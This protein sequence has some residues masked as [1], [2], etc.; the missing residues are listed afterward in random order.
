MSYNWTHVNKM[1]IQ[2]GDINRIAL[3][4]LPSLGWGLIIQGTMD[5]V[6][7]LENLDSGKDRDFPFRPCSKFQQVNQL[8]LEETVPVNPIGERIPHTKF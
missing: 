3:D 5:S 7:I 1:D 4:M 8:L 6:P 2:N